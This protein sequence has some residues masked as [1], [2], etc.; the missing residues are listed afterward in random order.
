[1]HS[2]TKGASSRLGGAILSERTSCSTGR[3]RGAH[4]ATEGT[5]RA[6]LLPTD[7][8]GRPLSV[9]GIQAIS[10]SLGALNRFIHQVTRLLNELR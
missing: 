9:I 5:V 4:A 6:S 7:S 2:Q 1:M 8:T 3:T 10:T